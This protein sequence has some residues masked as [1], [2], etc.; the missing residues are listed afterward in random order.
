M[1]ARASTLRSIK[2]CCS[3]GSGANQS[4]RVERVGGCLT[5]ANCLDSLAGLLLLA[6]D[7]FWEKCGWPS[8]FA[9]SVH[10]DAR[11]ATRLT[12]T[13]LRSSDSQDAISS[14]SMVNDIGPSRRI[15]SWSSRRTN[16]SHRSLIENMSDVYRDPYDDLGDTKTRFVRLIGP[17]TA[18]PQPEGPRLRSF[19]DGPG[20]TLL[21]VSAGPDKAVPWT[22]PED[23]VFDFQEPVT[24]LGDLSDTDSIFYVRGDGGVSILSSSIPPDMFKALVTP[25]GKER[26]PKEFADFQ[27]R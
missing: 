12:S 23:V 10:G 26:L 7:D 21:A 8:Q 19:L 11:I 22:K 20:N 18:F 24:C 9:T 2:R 4:V 17:G 5:H 25:A 15:T 13:G 27:L 6:R 3:L 14:S 1:P 16:C